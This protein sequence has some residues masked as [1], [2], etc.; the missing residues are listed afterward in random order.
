MNITNK[1]LK[2]LYISIVAVLL[3]IV[4]IIVGKYGALIKTTALPG[5]QGMRT[6]GLPQTVI[7]HSN[8]GENTSN[9]TQSQFDTPM[10]ILYDNDSH[11]LFVADEYNNRILVFDV[12]NPSN[13][14]NASYVLGQSDFV[15]KQDYTDPATGRWYMHHPVDIALDKNRNLLFVATEYFGNN[16]LVYFDL[17]NISDGTAFHAID[18]NYPSVQ[19]PTTMTGGI[20]Y[21]NGNQRLYMSDYSGNR[22]LVFDASNL[23]NG[24]NAINVIGQTDYHDLDSHTTQ[25]GLNGPRGMDFN[26]ST[27][28]LAVSDSVNHRVLIFGTNN[29]ADGMNASVVLGQENFT[30]RIEGGNPS[31]STLY[32]TRKVVFDTANNRL[33]ALDSL[34]NRVLVFAG[35]LSSSM[36]ASYVLG[37]DGTY[38]FNQDYHGKCGLFSPNGIAV[39]P[40]DS[41]VFVSDFTNAIYTNYT[42]DPVAADFCNAINPSPTPSATPSP[43]PTPTATPTSTPSVPATTGDGGSSG[44]GSGGGGGGGGSGNS[45]PACVQRSYLFEAEQGTINK[46]TALTGIITDGDATV[47]RLSSTGDTLERSTKVA[48]GDYKLRAR[49]KNDAPGPVQIDVLQNG[50]KIGAVSL[51]KNDNSYTVNNLATLKNFA[52]GKI[53]LRFQNDFY[54]NKLAGDTEAK[55]RNAFI[56]YIELINLSSAPSCAVKKTYTLQ[57]ELGKISGSMWSKVV[58][59]NG[60]TAVLLA[61]TGDAVSQTAKVAAGNYKLEARLKHDIPAPV[62]VDILLNNKKIKS[63]S[64]TKNNDAYEIMAVSTLKNFSGGTI[65]VRFQNDAF[66]AAKAGNPASDRN[67]YVD[68]VRLTPQ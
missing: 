29:L 50:K 13:G 5:I 39:G 45:T 26:E 59:E 30:S 35:S 16:K 53:T 22:I 11:R 37:D 65:T 41:Q 58:V 67:A 47:A 8:F 36:A 60:Q 33:L 54:D 57:S 25:N 48:R 64:L 42:Y 66:D 20:T 23:A 40:D 63:F 34:N 14:M 62:A 43:T 1:A 4:A 32:V 12:L 3:I 6:G 56:D 21:D 49:L 61:G 55:D 46:P 10:G 7:G 19:E 44:G 9:T 38:A 18:I 68:W 2:I 31:L 52:S 27:K 24:L 15:S 17:S 51:A 28:Q